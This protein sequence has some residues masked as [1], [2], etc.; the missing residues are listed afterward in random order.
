MKDSTPAKEVYNHAL[1]F[2]RKHKS[3]LVSHVSKN[4]GFLVGFPM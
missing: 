4:V 1:A 3:D 2:F